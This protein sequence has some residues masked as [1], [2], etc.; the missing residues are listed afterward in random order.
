MTAPLPVPLYP[1]PHTD[2]ATFHFE[3][4]YPLKEYRMA[5]SLFTQAKFYPILSGW[6]PMYIYLSSHNTKAP[7]VHLFLLSTDAHDNLGAVHFV[8]SNVKED[9]NGKFHSSAVK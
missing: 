8:N 7:V 6:L 9:K 5:L 2:L 3:L 1:A 4:K